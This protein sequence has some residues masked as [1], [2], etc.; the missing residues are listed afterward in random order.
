MEVVIG[1]FIS[2]IMG[3]VFAEILYKHL[4]SK[5]LSYKK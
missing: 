1:W 2:R 5:S 4:E 3:W